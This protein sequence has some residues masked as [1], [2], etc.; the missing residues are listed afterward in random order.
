MNARNALVVLLVFL[1]GG[2]VLAGRENLLKNP[3]AEEGE[4]GWRPFHL[5]RGDA[6]VSIAD[7]VAHAGKKALCIASRDRCF[8]MWQQFVPVEAGR[9]YEF[10]GHMKLDDVQGRAL[11]HVVFRDGENRVLEFVDL[12]PH[13]RT[14]DWF[15]AYPA[16]ILVRA[17]EKAARAEVNLCLQGSGTVWF[18]DVYFGPPP[19][20]AIAGKVTAEGKAVA[21][22]R[23]YLYGSPFETRSNER[24]EF[25]I[26]DVPVRS[27]R[28][29]L[30]A[31]K[32][33]YRTAAQGDLGVEEGKTCRIDVALAA[34]RDPAD[35]LL[36][37]KFG[38]LRRIEPTRARSVAAEAVIDKA[39]YP[40]DVKVYLA[41]NEF[42]DSQAPSVKETAA[43][44][45]AGLSEGERRSGSAVSR[46]VF[47][48]VIRSIEFD[49]TY[50][51]G[52][53]RRGP[54]P[55]GRAPHYS[56]SNFTDTTSGKWQTISP[57]GWC[58]GHNFT[59][60]LY[61][62][63]E[64]L[65]A[66]RGICIEHSRL[67]TGLLRACGIPAR[68]VKPYGC[69]FWVQLP[70]GDGYWSSMSTNGGRAAYRQRG[71]T[72]AG[73]PH[74]SPSGVHLAPIDAGPIIH[75]DWHTDRKCLWREVHPWGAVYPATEEG[76]TQALADL[77]E[78]KKT[79]ED[80]RRKERRPPGGRPPRGGDRAPGPRRGPGDRPDERERELL[81][82]PR[83]GRDPVC[84]IA[85][86]DVTV[87]LL[88]IGD[89]KTL[90]VRFPFPAGSEFVQYDAKDSVC[91][92]N[93]RGAV[94]RTWVSEER[95]P[96]FKA[97]R[98]FFNMEFDVTKVPGSQ[99][100]RAAGP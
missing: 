15:F 77:S 100:V 80:P 47:D 26:T 68:P 57:T 34:G 86:S 99:V 96:P 76:R 16:V 13:S 60:W 46:A 38:C 54:Q 24:G 1:M 74:V 93:H 36:R 97:V 17:P 44:I 27:P 49:T 25:R 88:T 14:I 9:V 40:D 20:G 64:C 29:I 45:L 4:T 66:K 92:T 6:R 85:Y 69:Q 48:W 43:A 10:S 58:W 84:E 56:P 37:V 62:P 61:K 63:S 50:D 52:D 65:T 73:Y 70:D 35:P 81:Q 83:R 90:R 87:N 78:F 42:I 94:V 19:R 71:E 33:G 95:N 5:N 72:R 8:A 18:D 32:D 55:Q 28:Y 2:A 51:P 22:A 3:G 89:Q 79:G 11:L 98:R 67:A 75:S 31:E 30:M 53:R 39:L 21:G 41:P 91:W 59:D 82:V 12:L 23:V 7:G